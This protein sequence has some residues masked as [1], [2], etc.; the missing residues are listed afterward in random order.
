MMLKFLVQVEVMWVEVL[1]GD[2][3]SSERDPK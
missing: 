3:D 1:I 2:L